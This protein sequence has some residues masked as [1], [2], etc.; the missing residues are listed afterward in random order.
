[1][2]AANSGGSTSSGSGCES[3]PNADSDKD[4]FTS[5]QGD[6]NDCD[7]NANPNA[8]EVIG[9]KKDPKYVPTDENCD[10]MKDEPPVACDN[11][12]F[13]TSR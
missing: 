5:D 10:G 8:V 12:A 7:A 4:G 13:P 1:M 9:D 2:S 6:C 11:P 3:A